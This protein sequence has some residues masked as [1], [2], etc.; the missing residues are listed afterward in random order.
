M[1]IFEWLLT[2]AVGFIL[3]LL[4]LFFVA[5]RSVFKR[6]APLID[7]FTNDKGELQLPKINIKQAIGYGIYKF[8]DSIDFSKGLGGILGGKV[9]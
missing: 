9:K 5:I 4:L 1:D 6:I 8:V 2:G 7:Q 3:L